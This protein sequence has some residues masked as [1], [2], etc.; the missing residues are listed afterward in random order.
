MWGESME[1]KLKKARVKSNQ[2]DV[3]ICPLVF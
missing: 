2:I 3:E 1:E